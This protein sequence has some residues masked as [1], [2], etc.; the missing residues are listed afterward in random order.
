MRLVLVAAVLAAGS[1]GGQEVSFDIGPT[2]ACLAAAQGAA[3]AEA[4]IG[5][6][7]N[8][9]MATPDGS[10]TVGMGYCLD[11]EWQYWDGR[12]NRAYGDLMKR[13]KADDADMASMGAAVPS[14]AAGLKAMQRAWIPFRDAACDYERAQWGGGTGGGP[15]TLGCLML[16]TGRQ[17]L[18]LQA[19]LDG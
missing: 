13:H 6:A 19:R 18:M 16:L 11:Q 3:Q 5:A 15:A 17:A 8:A 10:T 9:C 7:A 14:L 1:A 12:L 2:E 4:C